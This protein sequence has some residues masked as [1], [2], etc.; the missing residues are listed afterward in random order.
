M[1]RLLLGLVDTK[2]S[3][4]SCLRPTGTLVSPI[5]IPLTTSLRT[6]TATNDSKTGCELQ[7]FQP[8]L[9]FTEGTTTM[10]CRRVHINSSLDSV[11]DHPARSRLFLKT[12]APDFPVLPYKGTKSIVISTV[13]W[14]GGKNPF[15]GWAYVAAAAVFILL[16]ILGTARHLIKPRQVIPNYRPVLTNLLSRR[17]GDMSLL[18]WN[19]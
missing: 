4:T 11:R 7:V 10:L 17:L 15:L 13:S 5:I 14:V 18:S 1:Q 3:T 8:L 6:F 9:N 2:A 19:R 12:F 16:A